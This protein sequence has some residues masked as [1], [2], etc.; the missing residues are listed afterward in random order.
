MVAV[1]ELAE[2]LVAEADAV[3]DAVIDAADAADTDESV[4]TVAKAGYFVYKQSTFS[5]VSQYRF[6]ASE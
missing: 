2:E 3:T 4:E 5:R 6:R 1:A